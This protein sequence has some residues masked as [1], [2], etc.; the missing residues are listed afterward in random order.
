[1]SL[2]LLERVSMFGRGRDGNEDNV[3]YIYITLLIQYLLTILEQV[4]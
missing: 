4:R 2:G 1:M 3:L